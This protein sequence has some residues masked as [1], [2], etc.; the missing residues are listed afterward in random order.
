[1]YYFYYLPFS[2]NKPAE[3]KKMEIK[4]LLTG[5]FLLLGMS[6]ITNG[7][8][9]PNFI[10]D[11]EFKQ[12]ELL[13][14]SKPFTNDTPPLILPPQDTARFQT[15]AVGMR[16][17]T[18]AQVPYMLDAKFT[19]DMRV[20]V[21]EAINNF[22]KNTCIRF[23]PK[24]NRHTSWVKILY[25][26]NVCG[27]AH[28]CMNNGAQFAKF[29]G[30]CVTSGVMTHELGHTLCLGHEQTRQDRD[31]WIGFDTSKCSPPGKDDLPFGL[32]KLY[33]YVS[34]EHY[35]GECYNGCYLPKQPG[36]TKCGSGGS[37]SVLDI[38]LLNEMYGCNSDCLGYRFV[39]R[40]S[41]TSSSNMVLI[42]WE[43]DGTPLYNCRVYHQG[44]IIPGKYHTASKNC[45][46]VWGGREYAKGG[47]DQIE[48]LTNPHSNALRWVRSDTLPAGAIRGGRTASRETLYVVSC[49]NNNRNW[50]PGSYHVS[51]GGYYGF[52]GSEFKCKS[53][54][55]E[56]LVCT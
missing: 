53:G 20:R 39:N 41:L 4:T 46:I 14:S 11:E 23:V 34:I 9:S 26:D 40:N 17:W 12:A 35:E 37:L 22:H 29:G 36:V 21:A 10:T 3:L 45:D 50:M 27:L 13:S 2:V 38:E 54:D 7:I 25:D 32:H 19:A 47:S 55:M 24:Q 8:S 30:G 44:D 1:M 6:C 48:V 49:L 52:G 51:G 31:N 15:R 56:F 5:A 33:D 43:A 16:I 28:M 42:G 18:N